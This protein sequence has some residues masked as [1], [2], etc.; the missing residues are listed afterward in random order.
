MRVFLDASAL[1][2]VAVMRDQWRD[3]LVGHLT[4]L[5]A[6]GGAE[7][8]T[9]NWTFYEAAAIANRGGH[10]LALRLRQ[11]VD[12]EALVSAVTHSVEVEAVRRFFTWAD[13][14]ASVVDHANLLTAMELGCEAILS[15]DDDFVQIAAGTGI[16]I[17]R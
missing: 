1:V 17:L 5:R 12:Q 3:R 15:F 7:L 10:E 4:R 13:K 9:T 11:F 2:P 8:T 14:T 6:A 16:R